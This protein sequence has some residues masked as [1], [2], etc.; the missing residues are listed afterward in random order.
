MTI[1]MDDEALNGTNRVVLDGVMTEKECDRILQLAAVRIFSGA[2]GVFLKII[3]FHFFFSFSVFSLR[4]QH[5]L[6]MVTRDDGLHT[7]LMKHSKV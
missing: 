2:A 3:T 4:W 7:H 6:G 1:S 5:L